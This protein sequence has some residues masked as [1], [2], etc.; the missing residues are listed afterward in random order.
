MI[1]IVQPQQGHGSCKLRGEGSSS[2]DGSCSGAFASIRRA[3][4]PALPYQVT[5]PKTRRNPSP[6][7]YALVEIAAPD[8]ECAC[9]RSSAPEAVLFSPL[10]LEPPV[11]T[12]KA[13]IVKQVSQIAKHVGLSG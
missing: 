4:H 6:P 1:R 7:G 13:S 12:E 8:P 10:S 2:A 11:S 5:A 3:D 9:P